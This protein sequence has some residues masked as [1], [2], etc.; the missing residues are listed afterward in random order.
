[1][2]VLGGASRTGKGLISQELMVR[3]GIPYLSVDPIKMAISRSIPSYKLDIDGASVAVSEEMWPFISAFILNLVE[4]KVSYIV[5]GEILPS[6]VFELANDHG[7]KVN[8]CFVV[9][10][11]ASIEKKM[12]QVRANS[13]YPNDWTSSLADSELRELIKEGVQ[14]SKYLSDECQKYGVRYIDFSESFEVGRKTTLE[15]LCS[16]FN[17]NQKLAT[18]SSR[19]R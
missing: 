17:R 5:E 7:V 11:D 4:T 10:K 3:L 15:Y 2:I 8:S 12:S 14:Y 1:M 16:E 18:R 13:G 19:I 9:Y 6:H